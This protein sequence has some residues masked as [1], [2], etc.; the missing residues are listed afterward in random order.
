MIAILVWAVRRRRRPRR[1][2]PG[3]PALGAAL[4]TL[5]RIDALGLLDAGE[6]GRHVALVADALRRYLAGRIDGAAVGLTTGELLARLRGDP[7]VP[8]ER[9]TEVLAESDSVRFARAAVS[10]GRAAAVATDARAVI[11]AVEGAM[12]RGPVP[13]SAVASAGAGRTEAA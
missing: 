9:L 1:R 12:V 5:G 13:P 11:T 7:R 6:Y 4:E 2:A 8:I 10:R 3:P